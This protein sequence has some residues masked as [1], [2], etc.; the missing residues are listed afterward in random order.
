[1]PTNEQDRLFTYK[2]NIEARS[3]IIVAAEKQKVQR[4]LSV[5]L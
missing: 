2:R 4:V 1:M 3:L 5:C